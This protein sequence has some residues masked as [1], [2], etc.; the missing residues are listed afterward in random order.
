M[1]WCSLSRSGRFTPFEIAS[2]ARCLEGYLGIRA[3]L[4]MI[5]MFCYNCCLLVLTGSVRVGEVT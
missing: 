4:N 5:Q 3:V 1:H 2:V